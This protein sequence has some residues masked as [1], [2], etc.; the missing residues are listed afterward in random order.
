MPHGVRSKSARVVSVSSPSVVLPPSGT[1]ARTG[2]LVGSLFL[3]GLSLAWAFLSMRVVMDVG[4]A[5]ADGGP[6][7]IAQPCPTGGGFVGIAIPLMLIAAFV[8]SFAAGGLSA[9]N[10]LVPMWLFLFGSLGWNFLEYGLATQGGQSTAWIV[11]G[12]VFEL[13][14]LPALG[15][16][17]IGVTKAPAGREAV[18]RSGIIIWVAAYVVVGASGALVGVVTF[19]AWTS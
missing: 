13:M 2:L 16:M 8:G 7:V 5:C 4:G 6:Y 15:V 17:L 11:C 14:A 9:P 10:L 12:V 19:N 3:M 1:T 18:M